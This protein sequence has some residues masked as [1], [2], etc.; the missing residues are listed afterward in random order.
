M[1][2]W[3]YAKDASLGET[4]KIVI[5]DF[6]PKEIE[7]ENLGNVATHR[8][9]SVIRQRIADA[10]FMIDRTKSVEN[11]SQWDVCEYRS[12]FD[13]DADRSSET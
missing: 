2:A 5:P 3:C 11:F 6:T 13:P 10:N 8:V 7:E 9:F 1:Y 4:K 12:I